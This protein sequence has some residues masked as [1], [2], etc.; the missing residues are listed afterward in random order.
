V[1]GTDAGLPALTALTLH[2]RGML[3]D[4]VRALAASSLA[5]RL[6][7]LCLSSCD[8]GP[9]AVA[10]LAVGAFSGLSSLDLSFNT[11]TR[12]GADALARGPLGEL[13]RLRLRRCH[14][15]DAGLRALLRP[16]AFPKLAILDL[17]DNGLSRASTRVL[18]DWP[19]LPHL[20]QL[21]SVYFSGDDEVLAR[22]AR[23][24]AFARR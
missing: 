2:H 14:L 20:A 18:L 15:G 1:S 10:A 12:Q 6:R 3:P 7:H 13:V 8:L 23:P 4:A 17:H 24:V 5:P 16:E 9:D 21:D 19:R 11:V 22:L